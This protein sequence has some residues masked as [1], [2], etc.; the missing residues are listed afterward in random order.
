[1]NFFQIFFK[2]LEVQNYISYKRRVIAFVKNK[3]N[4]FIHIHHS[5]GQDWHF[6]TEYLLILKKISFNMC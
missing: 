4:I 6:L 1:M 5:E 3:D 2:I